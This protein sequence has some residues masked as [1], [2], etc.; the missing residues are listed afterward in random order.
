MRKILQL[1]LTERH[2]LNWGT[3]FSDDSSICQVDTKPASTRYYFGSCCYELGFWQ[4]MSPNIPPSFGD[5]WIY[6]FLTVDSWIDMFISRWKTYGFHSSISL[7]LRCAH[8][9]SL[10]EERCPLRHETE[11]AN[12]QLKWFLW[13]SHVCSKFSVIKVLQKFTVYSLYGS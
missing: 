11:G 6:V 4:R 1:N 8:V 3:F 5:E 10:V 7:L 13:R 9:I 12:G 2:V